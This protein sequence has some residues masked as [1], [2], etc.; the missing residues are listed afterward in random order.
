MRIY[1]FTR[2]N[3]PQIQLTSDLYSSSP[4]T[5]TF[6]EKVV[7]Q[8]RSEHTITK[9]RKRANTNERPGQQL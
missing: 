4:Q 8:V 1:T 9:P 3:P 5:S 2:Q 7:L 6:L